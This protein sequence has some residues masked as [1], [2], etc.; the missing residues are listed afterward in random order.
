MTLL[1]HV[2]I[3]MIC[4]AALQLFLRMAVHREGELV[5]ITLYRTQYIRDL[6]RWQ[7]I[8]KCKVG[9]SEECCR[10]T[11]YLLAYSDKISAVQ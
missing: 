11:Y 2:K 9:K 1:K 6:L 3:K 8:E 4:I 10:H 5:E 7:G